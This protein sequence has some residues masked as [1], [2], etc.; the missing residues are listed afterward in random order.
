MPCSP[1]SLLSASCLLAVGLHQIHG[2]VGITGEEAV[3]E[4]LLED[5][6]VT[7]LTLEVGN[8]I[9]LEDA[10]KERDLDNQFV[11]GVGFVSRRLEWPLS[12]S[13]GF[14]ASNAE[15]DFS[16]GARVQSQLTQWNLGAHKS[17]R[18]GA[19]LEATYEAGLTMV[20]STLREYRPS[21]SKR[22]STGFGGYGEFSLNY[23]SNDRWQIGASARYSYAAIDNISLQGTDVNGGGLDLLM[24][25]GG[26]F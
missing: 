18:L 10:W 6:F 25:F 5:G 11:W 13:A 22:T 19:S 3:L 12:I 26:R 14:L 8:K 1:R 15:T 9:M 20:R 24:T 21:L 2:A 4:G 17:W 23:I 7:S 16:D